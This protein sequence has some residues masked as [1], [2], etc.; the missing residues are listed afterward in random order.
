MTL[1]MTARGLGGGRLLLRM[2]ERRRTVLRNKML[3]SFVGR[4][5][6]RGDDLLVRII[7][8][9]P[10]VR[11]EHRLDL[12]FINKKDLKRKRFSKG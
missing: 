2:P 5:L 7:F 4:V 1:I 10:H 6:K 8:V 12:F 11:C 3:K 9:A